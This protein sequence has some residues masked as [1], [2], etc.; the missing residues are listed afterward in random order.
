MKA[1]VMIIF[2]AQVQLTTLA[3]VFSDTLKI[4]DTK[5]SHLVCPGKVD[6]VQVGDHT[7]VQAEVVPELANMVR[8][9]ATAPFEKPSSLT[10]VCQ[11]LIYTFELRYGNDG[12]ITYPVDS[13]HGQDA[14]TFSGKL[15]AD[16]V[17]KEL[18]DQILDRHHRRGCYRK[19]K[20]EK[21]GIRIRLHSIH[22]KNDALFFELELKN[23]T[24]M[25]YDVESIYFWITDKR[26]VKATNIQEYRVAP[27]YR[28]NKVTRIPGKTSVREVFVFEKLT[29]PDGRVLKLELNEKALR[30]TGR[31]LSFKLRNKDIL[32]ARKL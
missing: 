9:K 6:Y 32:K 11:D 7:L 8:I 23:A 13:F 29:I 27:D 12:P 16:H 24:Q 3:Q 28:H 22:L 26:K 31:K 15:M 19:R 17:L 14:R 30:N 20:G 10:V 18:C 1:I 25:A 2:C 21:D 5:T 4:S